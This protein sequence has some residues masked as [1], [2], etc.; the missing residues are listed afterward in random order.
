MSELLQ[1][2][3]N[4]LAQKK[5]AYEATQK[6]ER[7]MPLAETI[8]LYLADNPD[9][10]FF[11]WELMG[12]TKWGWLSHATHATLRVLEQKGKITK[13]HIGQYVVYTANVKKDGQ[14][15]K[16]DKF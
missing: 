3:Q 2:Q 12:H 1:K 11:V 14:V 16:I 8:L 10:W 4:S 7:D 6:T 13:D 15:L 9:K 5:A